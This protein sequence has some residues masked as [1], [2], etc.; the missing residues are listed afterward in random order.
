MPPTLDSYYRGGPAIIPAEL[1]GR[2]IH[3]VSLDEAT[4]TVTYLPS[5][6][7]W[8]REVRVERWDAEEVYP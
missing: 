2:R 3:V 4:A 1:C 8:I 7:G 6:G 5:E